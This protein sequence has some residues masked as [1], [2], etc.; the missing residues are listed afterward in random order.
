MNNEENVVAEDMVVANIDLFDDNDED[1]EEDL[2]ENIL[3][4]KI[5]QNVVQAGYTTNDNQQKIFNIDLDVDDA[6]NPS[7][8]F[9]KEQRNN[10]LKQPPG[11]SKK[12]SKSFCSSHPQSFERQH[13]ILP[14]IPLNIVQ[15][16]S[17]YLKMANRKSCF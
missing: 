2:P 10:L 14:S 1:E 15:F 5:P 17:S 13:H 6:I 9:K 8:R 12:L 16:Q 4:S 3:P 7:Y 11:L